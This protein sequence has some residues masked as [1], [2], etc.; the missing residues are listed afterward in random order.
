MRST[1]LFL[2]FMLSTTSF[3]ETGW[4]VGLI[5]VSSD[6][7]ESD[8]ESQIFF[9]P[10]LHSHNKDFLFLPNIQYD[11]QN[12]S[13]GL[14][15][16]S[17]HSTKDEGKPTTTVKLGYPFSYIDISG[18]QGLK[19]YG[20]RTSAQY[21]DGFAGQVSVTAGPLDYAVT[22]GLT[23][24]SDQFGQSLKLSAPVYFKEGSPTA[25]TYL[26]LTYNNAELEQHELDLSS[27]LSE[28]SYLHPAI[29]LFGFYN[30][31]PQLSLFQSFELRYNDNDLVNE[32]DDMTHLSFNFITVL[33][34]RFG[35]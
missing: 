32:I 6:N 14:T 7:Y 22:Q 23:D 21:D 4:S 10:I 13:A 29:G 8:A 24:R 12:G 28:D 9:P 3:A 27:T 31:T 5:S 2:A 1:T 33:T 35:K 15:G 26:S 11:W 17:W 34:Y 30:V 20:I 16:I 25:F 18:G 19:R